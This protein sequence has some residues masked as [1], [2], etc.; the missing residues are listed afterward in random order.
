MG[1]RVTTIA[2]RLIFTHYY[3][4]QHFYPLTQQP[5][6]CLGLPVI[7]SSRPHSIRNTALGRTRLDERSAWQHKTLARDRHPC[8]R[9]DSNPQSQYTLH[10]NYYKWTRKPILQN[11]SRRIWCYG[12]ILSSQQFT[13]F[14]CTW[15]VIVACI[16]AHLR[17][18]SRTIWPHSRPVPLEF[19]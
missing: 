4:T 1:V 2:L 6:A 7:E 15:N 17:A 3:N 13:C 9:R 5:L 8:S 12:R 10:Y 16:S 18:T 11:L 19:T 14:Y